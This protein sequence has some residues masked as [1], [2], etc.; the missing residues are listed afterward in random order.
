MV[1]VFLYFQVVSPGRHH[2]IFDGLDELRKAEYPVYVHSMY[3]VLSYPY[4]AFYEHIKHATN[5]LLMKCEGF[6][7]VF[8]VEGRR[9]KEIEKVL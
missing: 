4:V 1:M 7:G 8:S 5:D 9:R 2:I 3:L 6:S